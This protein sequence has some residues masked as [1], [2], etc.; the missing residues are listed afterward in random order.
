MTTEVG[1]RVTATAPVRLDFAGGWTDVPPF[2]SREGGVVVSAAVSLSVH[3]TASWSDQWRLVAGELGADVTLERLS[4]DP[5]DPRVALHLATLRHFNPSQPIRLATESDVPPGSGL[6][7]SGA[8]GVALVEAVSVLEGSRLPPAAAAA[9]AF[10]IET[11]GAGVAGG[12]QDQYSAAHGGFNLMRFSDP[13]VSVERLELEPAFCNAL[14]ASTVL[15]YA[16]ASR[17]SGNTI[18]RV[19]AAYGRGDSR[20][21]GALGTMRDLAWE[22]REALV[23]GDLARTAALLSRNWVAQQALDPAMRTEDMARLEGAMCDAGVLGGKAAGSGAGGCMFFI[24]PRPAVAA[25]TARQLGCTVLPVH[26]A[27]RGVHLT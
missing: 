5:A 11:V 17:F 1:A 3:A 25:A 22:M 23:A 16:G 27:L 2:A 10:E 15:C 14:A 26:W 6:G 4:D 7:S 21:A 13:S 20:V 9:R 18:A 24:A 19:M 12:K 8:L